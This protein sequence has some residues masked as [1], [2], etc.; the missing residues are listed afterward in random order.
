MKTFDV[1]QK[2]LLTLG[3][4]ALIF[5][6]V[7]ITV[8]LVATQHGETP[9]RVDNVTAG[10]Y[11]FKVSLYDDPARAGFTLP[12]AIAPQGQ[13]GGQWTYHVTSMPGGALS[14]TPIRDSFSSD[15][16][17]PGGIQGAAE[18]TVQG[19]WTLQVEVDG[20]AGQQTFAVPVTAV[21]LPPIPIWL[22]WLLGFIP[23]Y[24]ITVFLLLQR[25]RKAL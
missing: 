20:P 5:L 22:G 21:T 25:R 23:I 11:R 18:I 10:P 24:G 6:L 13:T 1:L 9:A 4:I 19:P 16:R 17:V 15:P 12:F 3:V 14:A 8:S 7:E 2:L